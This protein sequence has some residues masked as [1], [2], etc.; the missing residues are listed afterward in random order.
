MLWAS[1]RFPKMYCRLVVRDL[2][3]LH[4]DSLIHQA[5]PLVV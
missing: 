1:V 4:V 3:H 2:M 5:A